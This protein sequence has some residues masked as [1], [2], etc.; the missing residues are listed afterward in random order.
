V[1]DHHHTLIEGAAGVA[2]AG[3]LKEK[4]RYAGQNVVIVLCGGNISRERLREVL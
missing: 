2:V 1:I 4:D 3:Y